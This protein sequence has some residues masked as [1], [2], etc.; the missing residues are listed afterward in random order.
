MARLA[1]A[2]RQLKR[3]AQV[4][5]SLVQEQQQRSPPLPL[6]STMDVPFSDPRLA[7]SQLKFIRNVGEVSLRGDIKFYARGDPD[8]LLR[9]FSIGLGALPGLPAEYRPRRDVVIA[10]DGAWNVHIELHIPHSGAVTFTFK[11]TN[12]RYLKQVSKTESEYFTHVSI[13]ESYFL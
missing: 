12:T 8:T 3:Q 4:I 2:E 6:P 9:E 10:Q 11:W 5:L 1:D 7:G 13:R